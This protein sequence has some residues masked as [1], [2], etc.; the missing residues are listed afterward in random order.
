MIDTTAKCE[1]N[2][3][4]ETGAS[5]VAFEADNN[6]LDLC[7]DD[8]SAHQGQQEQQEEQ[9]PSLLGKRPGPEGSDELEWLVN[10]KASRPRRLTR[11]CD[12]DHSN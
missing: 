1:D 5:Q 10:E 7:S 8:N 3:Y 11:I 12:L 4:G 6:V 9:P 2:K